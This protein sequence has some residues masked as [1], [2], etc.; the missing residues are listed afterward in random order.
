M[1]FAL[2]NFILSIAAAVVN[3]LKQSYTSIIY[4][5]VN[6]QYN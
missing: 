3:S 4:Y 2:L 1:C 6:K 5:Q